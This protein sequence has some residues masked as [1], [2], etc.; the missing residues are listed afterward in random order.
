MRKTIQLSV[1]IFLFSILQT[2]TFACTIFSA[3]DGVTVLAGNN[4]DYSDPDT[5]IVF[6][7][8][9]NGKNGRVYCG[10]TQFWWQTGMN[11]Q[12]LFFASA[13]TSFLEVY[14]S[15]QK[16]HY[17]RYLMYKCLEECSTVAEVLDVFDQ[18]NLDFLETMQLM[19]SDATGASVIIEGDPIHLKQYY[20][21]VMT[22]F[23]LSQNDPPYPCWRYNT[24]VDMFTNTTTISTDFFTSI[25]NATHQEGQYPT[26]FS[27]VYDLQQK[28][29]Y[30]YYQHNYNHVKMF[31]LTA[32]LQQGYH[33][34]SIS[35]LFNLSNPPAKP[36]TP[37]GQRIGTIGKN[38]S[39]TSS[40]TDGDGDQLYYLFD[41]GD[42][43]NSSWLGPYETGQEC[44]ET[45]TWTQKNSYQIK[46]KAKDITGAESVWSDPLPII[47]PCPNTPFIS[48]LL[49]FIDF[50]ITQFLL[51]SDF[52]FH[53]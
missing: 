36:T 7:P 6:Y 26:Q 12:G 14:N 53:Y 22:N 15:T 40:S 23:R 16:P 49:R 39:Y 44:T 51:F 32:E 31:N 21:Q 48:H 20:Y 25:C 50:L 24:A 27:T 41:W 29:I 5:Y 10:W 2:S 37:T 42:G 34:Y 38:Y 35:S 43:T 8:A 11:D 46:V 13:S 3:D 1:V 4:G 19:I 30:L 52:L 9:E 18:Y 33:I 28:F 45:H 17:A 47:M